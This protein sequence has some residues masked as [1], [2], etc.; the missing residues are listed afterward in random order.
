VSTDRDVERIV[1]SWMDEGVT[2]LPDRVLDLV[3]DQLPATP[4][5]RPSWLARRT[6]TMNSYARLGL[7][8]AAVLTVVI[9]GIGLFGKSPDVGPAISPTPSESAA[10]LDPLAGRW[11]AQTTTC[12]QQN[13]TVQAAGFT[14]EQISLSG[15]SCSNGGTNHYSVR[16][17]TPQTRSLMT[18]LDGTAQASQTEYRIV[19]NQ[20]L[21]QFYPDDPFCIALR[22]TIDG[23][24]LTFEVEHGCASTGD[25]PLNDQV[26]LTAI[27]QTSPFTRQP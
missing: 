6:P 19:D 22:Y 17:W 25:A 5:R 8:A 13:A 23:D 20:T 27:L 4:Q 15:W 11:A 7:V 10:A 3:L 12:E 21:E 18:I 16:F 26:A 2:Q 24:Q 1:R 14:A 9:V